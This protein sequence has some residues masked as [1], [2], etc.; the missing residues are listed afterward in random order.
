ML[1]EPLKHSGDCHPKI[2]FGADN[3]SF[4][5]YAESNCFTTAEMKKDDFKIEPMGNDEDIDTDS[6]ILDMTVKRC[7]TE[8]KDLKASLNTN[9]FYQRTE[10]W[11]SKQTRYR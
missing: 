7:Q 10:G 3:V 8:L 9:N 2:Y 6:E 11:K 5:L 4:P 1:E